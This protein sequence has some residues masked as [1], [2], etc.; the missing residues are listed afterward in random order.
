MRTPLFAANWKMHKNGLQ[1]VSW[2]R[3]FAAATKHHESNADVV[4]APPFTA[5]AAAVEATRGSR[6]EVAGQDCHFERQG[7]YTGEG[8]ASRLTD[9]GAKFVIFWHCEGGRQLADRALPLGEF[10]QHLAARG[11]AEGMK[12][13]IELRRL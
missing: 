6:I 9:A 4:I 5:I 11:V 1:A 10:A 13:G 7:A 3:E 8:R 12:D 2:V